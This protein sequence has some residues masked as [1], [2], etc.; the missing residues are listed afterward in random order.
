[1]CPA[2]CDD[3][4]VRPARTR[5]DDQPKAEAPDL[6]DRFLMEL[7]DIHIAYTE[8]LAASSSVLVRQHRRDPASTTTLSVVVHRTDRSAQQD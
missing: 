6:F 5:S 7:D 8:I 1:M 3:R 4:S 2:V